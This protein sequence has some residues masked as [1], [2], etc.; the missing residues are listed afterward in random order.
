MCPAVIEIPNWVP[1]AAASGPAHRAKGHSVTGQHVSGSRDGK[2]ALPLPPWWA[3]LPGQPATV[4]V[5]VRRDRQIPRTR[6]A[7][8][9]VLA[10]VFA[11]LVPV[12]LLSAWIRG[13][14]ISTNGYVAAVTPV[15][16]S[17]V[18]RAAVQDA[19]TTQVDAAL[20]HA[21]TNLP[22]LGN[23]RTSA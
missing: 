4:P 23:T 10:V 15:A 20:M 13:T 12:A 19:V 5:P 8:A 21:E 1:V 6:R 14:V 18:V 2:D 3:A 17:P 16:A 22:A 7:A 11:V 9:A